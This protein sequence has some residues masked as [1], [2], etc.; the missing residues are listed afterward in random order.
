MINI[1]NPQTF[2]KDTAPNLPLP[3]RSSL[4]LWSQK[5]TSEYDRI[6]QFSYS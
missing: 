3:I 1:K 2:K 6:R 4:T 5:E